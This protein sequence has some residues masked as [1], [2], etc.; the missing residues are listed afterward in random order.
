L[1][2][3]NQIHDSLTLQ[4]IDHQLDEFLSE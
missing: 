3:H 4:A 2:Q 1:D